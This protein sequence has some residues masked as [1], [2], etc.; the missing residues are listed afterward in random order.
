MN[1]FNYAIGIPTDRPSTFLQLWVMKDGRLWLAIT[2]YRP[3]T[4]D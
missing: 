4:T 1:G 2:D 3:P